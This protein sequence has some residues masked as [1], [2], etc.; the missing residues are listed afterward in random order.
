MSESNNEWGEFVS[1]NDELAST[2]DNFQYLPEPG[3][4]VAFDA[5]L[6]SKNITVEALVRVGAKMESPNTIAFGYPPNAIKYRDIISGRKWN[7]LGSKFDKLKIIKATAEKTFNGVILVEGETDAARA[8]LLYPDVDVAC[9]PV[10]ARTVKPEF[11]DQL[12][13]YTVVYIGLDNDEAGEDG[14]NK[15]MHAIPQSVRLKPE[16]N[17][18]CETT[19]APPLVQ[20]QK[21]ELPTLLTMG[22]YLEFDP[23]TQESWFDHALL[24]VTGLLVIHGGKGAYKSW[25]ALSMAAALAQGEDWCYYASTD[26]PCRVG[27][28]QWEMPPAYYRKRLLTLIADARDP[29]LL[30]ENFMPYSPF[31]RPQLVVGDKKSEDEIINRLVDKGI[32]CVVVDPIRRAFGSAGDINAEVD[33]RKMLNFFQRMMDQG[34]TV[35]T[36]H[37]DNKAASRAGGGSMFDMTGSGAIPGDADSI[38]GISSPSGTQLENTNL[39]NLNFY[40]RN[41]MMHGPRGMS[42]EGDDEDCKI[43]FHQEAFVDSTEK[44]GGDT[45]FL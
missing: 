9:A 11:V 31:Q 36:S 35:I 5:W 18:W 23:P 38:I 8:T 39:R 16:G 1:E 17:D 30:K 42:I 12:K 29:E 15:W 32:S 34:L 22:E 45:P 25:V 19:N 7:Y 43:L 6:D 26:E 14:A 21:I 2:W 4:N 13:H 37:H 41:G 40:M 28:L 44:Q 33:V 24:P 3:A 10:G 27:V 20:P